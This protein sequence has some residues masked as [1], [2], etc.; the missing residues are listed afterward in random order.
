MNT[1]INFSAYT[2]LDLSPGA[3]NA[4]YS[5]ED[6]QERGFF[7]RINI[8]EIRILNLILNIYAKIKKDF[9]YAI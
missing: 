1:G 6:A 2:E 9:T 7:F 4:K 8:R 5:R 3:R